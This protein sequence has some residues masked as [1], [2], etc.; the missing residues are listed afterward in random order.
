MKLVSLYV[1]WANENPPLRSRFFWFMIG[2]NAGLALA[3]AIDH[4]A[5]LSVLRSQ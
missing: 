2:V 4:Y 3:W 1:K 5:F